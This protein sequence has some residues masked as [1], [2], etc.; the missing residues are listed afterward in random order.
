VQDSRQV[1]VSD[2]RLRLLSYSE[3]WIAAAQW[4]IEQA[5]VS[6][7]KARSDQDHTGDPDLH[8]QSVRDRVMVAHADVFLR[9]GKAQN[10]AACLSSISTAAKQLPAAVAVMIRVLLAQG[11]PSA[12]VRVAIEELAKRSPP[13]ELILDAFSSFCRINLLIPSEQIHTVELLAKLVEIANVQSKLPMAVLKWLLHPAR[14]GLRLS[15][16]NLGTPACC[17]MNLLLVLQAKN[18]SF[19]GATFCSL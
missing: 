9:Q 18:L 2:E 6:G 1:A 14:S 11:R 15:A 10:A 5:E 3:Q 19:Y 7:P 4:S 12:S 17:S 13:F 8:T 16:A